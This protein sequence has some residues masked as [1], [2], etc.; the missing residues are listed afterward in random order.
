MVIIG[1]GY[2]CIPRGYGR[3]EHPAP[4]FSFMSTETRDRPVGVGATDQ[5][6]WYGCPE[7]VA[8]VEEARRDLAWEEGGNPRVF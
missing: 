3:A 5:R 7:G 6:G 4:R 2:S 8:G 1:F